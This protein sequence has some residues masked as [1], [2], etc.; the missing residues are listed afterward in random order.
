MTA[1]ASPIENALAACIRIGRTN[2]VVVGQVVAARSGV[3]EAIGIA[4]TIGDGVRVM[5]SDRQWHAAIIVGFDGNI[6]RLVPLGGDV[7]ASIGARVEP[8]AR[9]LSIQSGPAL[10]G[11][12]IDALGLPLDNRGPVLATAHLPTATRANP[13][14]RAAITQALESGVRAIDG[15]LTLGVGQR[16][17]LIAGSGVGKTT[18]LTQVIAG[19]AVDCVIM[20]LVGERSREIAEF[21]DDLQRCGA[22]ARTIV[23]AAPADAPAVLRI[24]AI[25]RATAIAEAMRA[26][27]RHVLLVADSLTRVAHAQRE[28]GLALGEPPTMKGYPPSALALLPRLI[29]RAGGDRISGGAITAV[30]T[31][32]ADGDDLDDP[33]VDTARGS[34][35]GHIILSRALAEHPH[36]D[37]AVAAQTGVGAPVDAAQSDI[38]RYQPVPHPLR[39]AAAV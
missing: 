31:V 13:L 6:A 37:R 3:I 29:E 11:R 7:P 4:P 33:V 27:G 16:V 1:T 22:F 12:V 25:D 36:P 38:G 14:N 8:Y 30:Y 28:L 19:A 20:A 24:R 21:V 17:A 10:F 18:L 15:L 39:D 34:A 5:G 26:E 23:I 9:A 2:P 32:L 35:D